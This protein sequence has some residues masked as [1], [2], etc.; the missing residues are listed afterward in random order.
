MHL[1]SSRSK[2][3]AS[4]QHFA[5]SQLRKNT[6]SKTPKY[7]AYTVKEREGKDPIW[8]RIGAAWEQPKAGG[9]NLELEALPLNGKIVLL[10]PKDAE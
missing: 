3:A 7:L 9:L 1:S 4:G 8:T 5:A 6:M 10:P 2:R